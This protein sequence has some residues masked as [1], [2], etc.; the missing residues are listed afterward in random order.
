[1]HTHNHNHQLRQMFSFFF[2]HLTMLPLSLS[3]SVSKS[4]TLTHYTYLLYLFSLI[5]HFVLTQFV[6]P[7]SF[8]LFPI[9]SSLYLAHSVS[10]FICIFIF[11]C[12][13][14]L[15]LY[16]FI[17]S[18][19]RPAFSVAVP[20]LAH[21]LVPPPS[22]SSPPQNFRSHCKYSRKPSNYSLLLFFTFVYNRLWC[23]M[24][25]P[26]WIQMQTLRL[27]LKCNANV[28]LNF[29]LFLFRFSYLS[30]FFFFFPWIYFA[31]GFELKWNI[32]KRCDFQWP[33]SF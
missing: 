2:A 24:V 3:H 6:W 28:C 33:S 12:Q 19:V 11:H 25:L 21:F 13:C 27:Q 8:P 29:S 7:V 30:F 17:H 16:S 1:M 32:L 20:L 18:F 22:S 14:K 4:C 15:H 5:T 26:M 10:V 23:F 31:F 9:N